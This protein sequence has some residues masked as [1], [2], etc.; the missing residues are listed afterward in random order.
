M[1]KFDPAQFVVD[2]GERLVMEFE[3]AA[4]AG[5][6]GLVGAA[7]EHPARTQFRRLLPPF[8]AVGSGLVIDS[9]G[10]QS[11]QQDL[12]VFERDL[13]PVYS[14]N[15][16]PEAT[17]YPV[18]GVAATGE[19][20]SVVSKKVLFEAL[21]NLRSVKALRRYTVREDHGLGPLGSYRSIGSAQSFAATAANEYD[22][23]TQFRDQV[24]SFVLCQKFAQSPETVLDNLIE[25]QRLNG[26]ELMPNLIVSLDGGFIQ[27]VRAHD[28]SLQF[29][30]L[31]SDGFAHVPAENAF[32]Y[33]I[34]DL[35]QNLRRSR[36]VPLDSL[37]RYLA[38]ISAKL[39]QCVA[40]RFEVRGSV[41]T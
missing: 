27:G 23:D 6:P 15:D 21:D 36:S 29:S 9:F 32:A 13:C 28:M 25:Y 34:Q 2:V 35:T 30:P 24:Y 16:T 31:A 12:V 26:H 17:Y 18:E 4:A 39:P 19:I 22:Q 20:K 1:T 10:G 41:A 11:M 8:A 14:L 37:D 5:T 7:R 33:L 40:R 3:L 38:P